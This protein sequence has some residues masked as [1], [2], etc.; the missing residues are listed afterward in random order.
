[1]GIKMK[2]F[3][4]F[5]PI[6]LAWL[7]V[8]IGLTAIH[9]T[10]IHKTIIITISLIFKAIPNK[11]MNIGHILV[12]KII[13]SNNKMTSILEITRDIKTRLKLKTTNINSQTIFKINYKTR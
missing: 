11:E 3:S 2:N 4:H 5:R 12:N 1:M 7:A 6:I 10:K 8:L 13:I 9:I